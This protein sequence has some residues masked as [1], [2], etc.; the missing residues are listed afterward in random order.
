MKASKI[1]TVRRAEPMY[2]SLQIAHKRR[3]ML[4]SLK[5]KILK[6]RRTSLMQFTKENKNRSTNS[7]ISLQTLA[8]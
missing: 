5:K 7:N 3:E 8:L 4:D 2:I 1:A 6:K